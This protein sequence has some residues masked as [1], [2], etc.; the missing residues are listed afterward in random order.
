MSRRRVKREKLGN[1][2]ETHTPREGE[3]VACCDLLPPRP[4]SALLW[5]SLRTS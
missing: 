5:G 2:S 1:V 4:T 3:D